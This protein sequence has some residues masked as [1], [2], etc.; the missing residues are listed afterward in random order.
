[1]TIT[2]PVVTAEYAADATKLLDLHAAAVLADKRNAVRGASLTA[3]DL[4]ASF[5]AHEGHQ[6]ACEAFRR[7]HHP[8]TYRVVAVFDDVIAVSRTARSTRLLFTKEAG[9]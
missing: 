2:K 1:M 9:R 5:D 7:K 3:T 4:Q 8:R 6:I